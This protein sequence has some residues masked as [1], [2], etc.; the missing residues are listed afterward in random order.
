[1]PQRSGKSLTDSII[2]F[3]A[4][5]GTQGA[6]LTEIYAAVR[7]ELGNAVLDTSIRSILY[8]RLRGTKSK[9]KQRFERSMVHGKY[10][11]KLL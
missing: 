8:K 9:Y 11:Y 6:A 7:A 3:L 4:T 10:R 5:T 1:M 2:T